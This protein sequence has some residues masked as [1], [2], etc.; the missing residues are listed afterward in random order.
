MNNKHLGFLLI[1]ILWLNECNT[2]DIN[3]RELSLNFREFKESEHL[4]IL[5]IQHSYL[6]VNLYKYKW[7]QLRVV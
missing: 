5:Y 4:H 2:L 6:G 3:P 1:R 7:V